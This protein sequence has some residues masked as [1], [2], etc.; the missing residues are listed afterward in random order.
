[1]YF[2]ER[3]AYTCMRTFTTCM[4]VRHW[5]EAVKCAR[6]LVFISGGRRTWLESKMICSETGLTDA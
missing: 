3:G 4:A 2:P 6:L 1:M 5:T